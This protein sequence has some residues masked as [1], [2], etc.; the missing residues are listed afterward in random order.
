MTKEDTELA[1]YQRL[2]LSVRD[3]AI[4]MLDP[5]GHVLSWNSGA[6]YLKGY[7]PE[8]I[9]GRHFSTFYTAADRERDHPAHEL[10]VAVA[11]GRYEEEGWRVRKDGSQF[12][13]S[14]TITAVRDD[15]G[16][17]TGFAKVT[18]DL[19]E[20]K[21]AEDALKEAVEQLRRSNAE[22]DRFAS[23][24]AHDMMDPLRTM[25]GFAE[26]LVETDPTPEERLQYA[27]HILDSGLRLSGMLQGLLAY[28]RSGTPPAAGETA[29]V[30]DTLDQVREDLAASLAERRA[31]V[32]ADVPPDAVVAASGHDL[33]AMLQNLVSNALKFGDPA[34]PT[35]RITA[36]REGAVWR[37]AVEDNGR[38]IA[39]ADQATIFNAFRRAAG[40]SRH[41][42]YG[43]GLAI[44]ERLVERRGGE[45]GVESAA[46]EGSRFWF[47]L[48]TPAA[49]SQAH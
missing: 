45:I 47:T 42:G 34:T 27:Q 40:S 25:S 7:R 16:R 33:R 39:A 49:A 8:E 11:E 46:G 28:A 23:V 12:W 2:V 24:A 22:L 4:F 3:Y 13:A 19:T 6:Q 35:V 17:L 48:P 29:V 31:Q 21:V 20:R 37:I 15:D 43:L 26:V 1:E 41:T 36:Q 5:T 38:G 14:V 10:E 32:T 44:C 18:R 30:A 9:I